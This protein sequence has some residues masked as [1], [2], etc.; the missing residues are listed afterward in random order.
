MALIIL[1]KGNGFYN[2]FLKYGLRRVF[3]FK[4]HI[5]FIFC[6]MLAYPLISKRCNIFINNF[7]LSYLNEIAQLLYYIPVYTSELDENK[8]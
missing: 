7:F 3:V 4:K 6:A 5:F 2:E 1:I 8:S